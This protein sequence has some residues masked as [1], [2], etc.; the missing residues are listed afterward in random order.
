MILWFNSEH[1]KWCYTGE[2]K[3]QSGA[4]LIS[5]I[6]LILYSETWKQGNVA[7]WRAHKPMTSG[8]SL[9]SLMMQSRDVQHHLKVLLLHCSS[10]TMEWSSSICYFL[11]VQTNMQILVEV[12]ETKGCSSI[13]SLKSIHASWVHDSPAEWENTQLNNIFFEC[14]K[15]R[16]SQVITDC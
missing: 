15:N 12:I 14:K 2:K 9:F 11:F 3:Q 16:S 8:A 13:L 10:Y 1:W 4:Q 5:E 6:T 7:E